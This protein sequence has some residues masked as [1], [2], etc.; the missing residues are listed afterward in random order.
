MHFGRTELDITNLIETEKTIMSS[1]PHFI[2]NAAAYTSVDMAEKAKNLAY[3]VNSEAVHNLATIAKKH[4]IHLI[5]FSTDYVFDGCKEKAYTEEDIVN[6]QSIYGKSKADGEKAIFESGCVHTVFRT[7]WVY[8][9]HGNN[10]AN[11]ILELAKTKSE[12]SIVDDQF[13][14]PTSVNFIA[15]MVEKYIEKLSKMSQVKISTKNIFNIVPSGKINWLNFASY[16]IK[17]LSKKGE[18]FEIDPDNLEG[19]SSE[20]YGA[21]AVRPANSCLSN[22]KLMTFLSITCCP[23]WAEYADQFISLKM[24]EVKDET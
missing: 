23:S 12:L 2:L 18:K 7:S 19:I 21:P 6:P 11:S 16:L 20:I 4:D 13:G 9:V 10:F 17:E 1:R 22:D 8:S 15:D 3:K 24:L 5:H 14:I